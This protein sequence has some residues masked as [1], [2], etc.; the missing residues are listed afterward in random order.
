VPPDAAVPASVDDAVEVP[1]SESAAFAGN[2]K[3]PMVMPRAR[4]GAV[5]APITACRRLK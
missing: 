3:P 1:V 5:I 2:A 4:I